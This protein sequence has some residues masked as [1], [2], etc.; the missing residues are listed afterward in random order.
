MRA[1]PNACATSSRASPTMT[2][3]TTTPE[4]GAERRLHPLSW[5]F[6]LLAQLRQFIV[7]LLALLLFGQ[8]DEYPLW[9]LIGVGALALLSGWQ[10]FTSRSRHEPYSKL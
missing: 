6:V 2:M 4:P 8:R 5:L 1:T 10:H 3:T 7:P 9:P